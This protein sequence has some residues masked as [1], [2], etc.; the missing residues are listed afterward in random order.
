MQ[1]PRGNTQASDHQ[2]RPSQAKSRQLVPPHSLG[3]KATHCSK[4]HHYPFLSPLATAHQQPLCTHAWTSSYTNPRR[5]QPFSR[6]S[7]TP[8]FQSWI[9]RSNDIHAQPLPGSCALIATNLADVSRHSAK[10]VQG[11]RADFWNWSFDISLRSQGL[12]HDMGFAPSIS[13]LGCR[14]RAS[15]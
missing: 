6:E 13:S 14:Y 4:P 15:A 8:K 7:R 10:H 2:T 3:P 9:H 11:N 5:A 12:Y 1:S